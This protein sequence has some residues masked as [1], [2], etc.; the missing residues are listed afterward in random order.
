MED[1]NIEQPEN[2][3]MQFS[4]E[5]NKKQTVKGAYPKFFIYAVIAVVFAFFTGFVFI[6]N[7]M[8]KLSEYKEKLAQYESLQ[9]ENASLQK[10]N[11]HLKQQIAYLNTKSGVESLAREKL[12]LIKPSEIAVVVLNDDKKKFEEQKPSVEEKTPNKSSENWFSKIWNTIF[13]H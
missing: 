4:A 12:G 8:A 1:N 5:D 6:K 2:A 13:G 7:Y 3:E 11:E 10:E 9:T